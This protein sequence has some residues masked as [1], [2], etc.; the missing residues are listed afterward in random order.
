MCSSTI[1]VPFSEACLIPQ[2]DHS[3]GLM[4]VKDI[5]NKYMYMHRHVSAVE[6]LY[7]SKSSKHNYVHFRYVCTPIHVANTDQKH[8]SERLTSQTQCFRSD[9]AGLVFITGY[10]WE[11]RNHSQDFPI[12]FA[13]KINTKSFSI[14][15]QNASRCHTRVGSQV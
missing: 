4:F 1:L 14:K 2:I 11:L 10:Y 7:Q 6:R 3:I 5:H 13:F 15:I 9:C 8:C 12:A